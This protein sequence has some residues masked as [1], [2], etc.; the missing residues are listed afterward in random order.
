MH[1]QLPHEP[2]FHYE[3]KCGDKQQF[4]CVENK[5]MPC[6][7]NTEALGKVLKEQDCTSGAEN[8]RTRAEPEPSVLL[9]LSAACPTVS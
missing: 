4:L 3:L 1:E 5:W 6:C 2:R 7:S 8:S 9:F